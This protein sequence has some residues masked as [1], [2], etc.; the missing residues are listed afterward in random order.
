VAATINFGGGGTPPLQLVEIGDQT[1]NRFGNGAWQQGQPLAQLASITQFD[2]ESI[3]E[4]TLTRLDASGQQP[5]HETVNGVKGLRYHFSGPQLTRGV[6]GSEDSQRP[7]ATATAA[8]TPPAGD[9]DL[10]LWTAEK[11]NYPLRMRLNGNTEG[12]SF[13]L[14]FDI[15][16]VNRGNI[17]I[18]RPR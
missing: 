16:D 10:T 13:G 2:P 3:C 4:S 15:T 7:R 17:Q 6:F 14:Q 18:V 12:A 5:A 1:Y 11:G 9:L 8:P